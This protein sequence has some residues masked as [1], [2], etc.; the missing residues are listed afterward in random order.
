MARI[1]TQC[2]FTARA[3]DPVGIECHSPNCAP[4]KQKEASSLPAFSLPLYQ[5][6]TDLSCRRESRTVGLTL[7]TTSNRRVEEHRELP[8]GAVSQTLILTAQSEK[9]QGNSSTGKKKSGDG[10]PWFSWTKL[11]CWELQ[12]KLGTP[13]RRVCFSALPGQAVKFRYQPKRTCTHSFP[14]DFW[15]GFPS[16]ETTSGCSSFRIE[17]T[18][19]GTL[20]L[21][22]T[23][24]SVS[25]P[26]RW[27]KQS[28]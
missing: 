22:V 8:R 19:L 21:Q 10:F 4:Q 2:L 7:Q 13:A 12:F 3:K 23:V 15:S 14:F 20:K 11:E 16:R 5:R 25:K 6:P 26:E 18:K 24:K 27:V 9:R 17:L 1:C 28:G